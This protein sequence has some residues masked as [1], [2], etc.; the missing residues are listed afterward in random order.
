MQ[1]REI[2]WEDLTNQRRQLTTREHQSWNEIEINQ[3]KKGDKSRREGDEGRLSKGKDED[4]DESEDKVGL[5]MD[6][7]HNNKDTGTNEHDSNLGN[8]T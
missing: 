2:C 6:N 3:S 4:E 1:R 8:S 5:K 7:S